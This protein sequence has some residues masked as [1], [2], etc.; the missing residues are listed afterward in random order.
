MSDNIF[1]FKFPHRSF[2]ATPQKGIARGA[3]FDPV[4]LN[5]STLRQAKPIK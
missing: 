5:I 1:T 4:R 2:F 3:T